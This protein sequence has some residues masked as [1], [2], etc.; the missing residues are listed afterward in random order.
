[1]WKCRLEDLHEFKEQY[2]H[3]DVTLDYTSNFYDLGL[4][5]NEQRILYQRAKE[6]IK[7]QLDGKRIKDLE[8]IG[9]LWKD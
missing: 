7:S 1:M 2:G 9:F 6:G 5:V 4:W 8:K 3:C